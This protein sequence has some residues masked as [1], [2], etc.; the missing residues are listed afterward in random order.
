MPQ[1]GLVVNSAVHLARIRGNAAASSCH[2][3]AIPFAR[4]SFDVAFMTLEHGS[5]KELF[6]F[7][8]A[9]SSPQKSQYWLMSAAYVIAASQV[10]AV[11]RHLLATTVLAHK[12][13]GAE[14]EPT[15]EEIEEF[16]AGGIYIAQRVERKDDSPEALGKG[17]TICPNTC[18]GLVWKWFLSRGG[19]EEARR[20][21]SSYRACCTDM[22]TAVGSGMLQLDGEHSLLPAWRLPLAPLESV[23]VVFEEPE[24]ESELAVDGFAESTPY[25]YAEFAAE[26]ALSICCQPF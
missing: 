10:V 18:A 14:E 7:G 24:L 2:K 5:S 20:R 22:G 17:A 3:T 8:W 16:L 1:L 9:D 25:F 11:G 26:L 6:R 12:W 13:D 21:R 4:L 23:T 19:V 15:E